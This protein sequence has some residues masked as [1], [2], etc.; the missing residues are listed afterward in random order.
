MLL[1]FRVTSALLTRGLNKTF[2]NA[3][4]KRSTGTS[5]R[6][7]ENIELTA[8]YTMEKVSESVQRAMPDVINGLDTKGWAV[9]DNF[10]GERLC[11]EMRKEAVSLYDS[12]YY[13]ISQSTRWDSATNSSISYDKHNVFSMQLDGG[14][15]YYIAPRLHEYMVSLTRS[16][17]PLLSTQY[18]EAMLSSTMMSNK[19]AVC[20]GNGS[21]YDKHYDNSGMQDT[22]KVTILYYMN[23]WRPE[24]G[25]CFR[26]YVPSKSSNNGVVTASR[27][28]SGDETVDIEPRADRLLV[29]WSDR[30][31]HS[32]QPSEAPMGEIDH[33]YALTLWLTSVTPDAIVRDDAEIKKHFGEF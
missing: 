15:Q 19:L 21:A 8:E 32:V 16:V 30:L 10:L 20:T 23:H 6:T 13:S 5:S 26:I 29:F 9:L 33:R 2:L 31:V 17:V 4:V 7:T 12:N 18:P 14:D 27:S 11:H 28:S 25:G 1:P 3:A 24:C 22:R